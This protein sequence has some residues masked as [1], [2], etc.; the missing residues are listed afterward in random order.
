MDSKGQRPDWCVLHAWLGLLLL[1]SFWNV[2][3]IFLILTFPFPYELLFSITKAELNAFYCK[4]SK[5][6]QTFAP[7]ASL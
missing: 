1:G 6:S 4:L 3:G 2:I 7:E 5:P